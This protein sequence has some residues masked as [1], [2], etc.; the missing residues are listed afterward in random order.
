MAA[1]SVGFC[2]VDD[3]CKIAISGMHGNNGIAKD[4][5]DT[6]YV[7][8]ALRGGVSVLQKQSD[9]TLALTDAV[10]T[11]KT[12]SHKVSLAPMMTTVPGSRSTG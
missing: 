7:A 1:S 10:G 5:N 9:N 12:F 11:R 4:K 8:N 2:H 3:G 6:F